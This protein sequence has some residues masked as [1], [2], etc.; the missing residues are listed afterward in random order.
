M[1]DKLGNVSFILSKVN[2]LPS[3]KIMSAKWTKPSFWSKMDFPFFKTYALFQMGCS[4]TSSIVLGENFCTVAKS[5]RHFVTLAMP[6]VAPVRQAKVFMW[7]KVVSPARV[8]LPVKV[9]SPELSPPPPPHP[10]RQLGDFHINSCLNFTTQGKVNSSKVTPGGLSRLSET[11]KMGPLNLD[12]SLLQAIKG[13]GV[14]T[15]RLQSWSNSIPTLT[16]KWNSFSQASELPT[17]MVRAA[18]KRPLQT[19]EISDNSITWMTKSV[20]S[21]EAHDQLLQKAFSSKANTFSMEFNVS[22]W[23]VSISY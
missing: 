23:A 10:P 12:V 6:R 9:R 7:G 4:N 17:Y 20:C 2:N 16:E 8:T 11:I 5:E 15:G 19:R 22:K 14:L 18:R 13:P 3:S 1:P 21:W